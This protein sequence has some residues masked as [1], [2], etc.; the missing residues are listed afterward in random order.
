M[1]GAEHGYGWS[2]GKV[3]PAT[4]SDAYEDEPLDRPASPP[5]SAQIGA[6]SQA[7]EVLD[8]VQMSGASEPD[9]RRLAQDA[10]C[11]LRVVMHRR[12]DGAALAEATRE[13]REVIE[14]WGWEAT[15]D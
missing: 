4:E 11:E 9:E 14:A 8:R 6:A 3:E 13:A 1:S 10:A 15:R 7:L 12:D 2:A 5:T